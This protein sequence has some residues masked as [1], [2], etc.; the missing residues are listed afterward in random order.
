[1]IEII[2]EIVNN[3]ILFIV[4]AWYGLPITI[5][6]VVLFFVKSSRDERGRAIIGK[7]SIIATIIFIILVNVVAVISNN[8]DVNY[9][10]M[11]FC[12]QWSY[13][14]VLTVEIIAILIYK[15]TE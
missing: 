5:A 14:I 2:N 8:M 11:G 10:S 9:I 3:R 4:G 6:L 1:M 15:K 12:F 7:A 13:D